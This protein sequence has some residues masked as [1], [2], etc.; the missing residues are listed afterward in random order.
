MNR[1]W[2]IVLFLIILT[3]CKTGEIDD[4]A[5]LDEEIRFE[6]TKHLF[7]DTNINAIAFAEPNHWFYASGNTITQ[8]KY[9]QTSVYTTSTAVISMD[10][11]KMEET[12]WFGT[13]SSGLGQLKNGV[14]TYFTKESHGLPRTNYI[15]DVTCDEDG[16]TWFNSSA[17]KQGGLGYHKNGIFTFYTPDNS[18]LPDNLVK[19][20]AC[21]GKSVYVAT[22]GYVNQQ[23]MVKISEG[24]FEVLPVTGYYL[25]DMAVD[26]EDKVYVIDDH[27]LSSIA[28]S[29][30]NILLHD[31]KSTRPIAPEITAGT[32][33]HPYILATDL[34]NYLWVAKFG[35]DNAKNL[36]VYDGK[37]WLEPSDFPD[38]FIKCLAVDK[39][40][41]L[42][43]GTNKGIYLIDQ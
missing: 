34:R 35:S 18:L 25:T 17:H 30:S 40:N 12:L 36:Q 32:W 29:R 8:V 14:I 41:T 21:N 28:I 39:K 6:I 24:N 43:I 42:W 10:W 9:D 15:R 7:P 1:I 20:I 4:I 22:G 37:E 31:G 11:N 5:L 16:G 23:K 13:D 38:A 27:S 3:G 19:S 2:Q 33:Y 26:K